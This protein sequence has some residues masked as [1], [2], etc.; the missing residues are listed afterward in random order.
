MLRDETSVASDMVSK[1]F[2]NNEALISCEFFTAIEW[3]EFL[4]LCEP[5][6]EACLVH[7]TED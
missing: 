7:S 3:L 4:V 1:V 6:R 5:S 2:E